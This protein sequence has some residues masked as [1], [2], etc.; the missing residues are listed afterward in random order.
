MSVDEIVKKLEELKLGDCLHVLKELDTAAVDLVYLDPPFFTQKTQKLSPRD[1]SRE[2]SFSD[3]WKSI[4]AYGQ[5]IYERLSELH[6]VLKSTGSLFFHC[7]RNASHIARLALDEIFGSDQFRSEIIW[8]YRRWSASQKT[9][10]PAH[11]NIFFYSKTSDYK[12]NELL[13]DYSASTNVDQILQKR[14]RDESGKAVYMLDESG[15]FIA[16]GK[17]KGVPLSDVWDIPYLNPKAQE[18]TGYPT[19]KPVLLLERI[20]EIATDKEDLVLDPFCGSGTTLVAAN[21]LGRRSIG[22]DIADEAIAISRNRLANPTKTRSR[23]LET[24]RESYE[25]A[26][27]SSL[28]L[29]GDLNVVPVQR[30]KGIDAFLNEEIGGALVPIRVQQPGESIFEAGNLLYKAGKVKQ[31]KVMILV[32]TSSLD[33]LISVPFPP[34]VLVVDS[35]AQGISKAIQSVKTMPPVQPALLNMQTVR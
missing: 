14:Q 31:A 8:Y 23:L 25:T 35:T 5:F 2:F 15:N 11:Q 26:N 32:A 3:T 27:A 16:N 24:G 34:E 12:F 7:D 29:L 20:I 1:R 6:R 28:A 21:L 19:Q 17:K 30:N 4:D 33:A 22:I 10:L 13:Q 9:L 18:R